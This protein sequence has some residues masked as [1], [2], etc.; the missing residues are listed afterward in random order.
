VPARLP[1]A[2]VAALVSIAALTCAASA[3]AQPDAPVPAPPPPHA[4]TLPQA[5]AYARANQPAVKMALAHIDVEKADAEVPRAAWLPLVGATAQIF[6]GTANNSTAIYSTFMNIPRIGGTRVAAPGSLQPYAS[7]FVGAALTQEVFDFGRIAAQTAAEDARVDV[8]RQHVREAMLDV[9]Y[10]VEE[11][12]FA[13]WAARDIVTA[14][15]QAYERARAHRDLAKAAVDSEMRTPIELARAEADLA[16]FDAGRIRARGGLRLAQAVFA[17]A[18]GVADVAL[19]VASAPPTPGDLPS[20]E[21]SVQ[22]ASARDPR[23]LRVLAEIRA[24]EARTRAIGAQLRPDVSISAAVSGRAGGAP[25]SGNGDTVVAEGFL[26]YVPNWDVGVLLSWPLFDGTVKAREEASRAREAE[27]RQQLDAARYEE[28]ATI[29]AAYTNVEVARATV[30]AL[31]R[32]LEAA[33][34]NYAQA[35]ARFRGGLGTTVELADAEA[36]RTDAQIQLALGEF[37]LARARAAFG[38]AIAEGS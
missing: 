20:L 19:D 4:M 17:A 23:I 9:R 38:R 5:I 32:A 18:V 16:R 14:S 2:I 24:E 3:G 35:D 1:N 26:P 6:G 27:R 12:Y 25:P 15:D 31:R 33:E 28:T 30:P 11:A 8:A 22:R 7:T 29:R 21:D 34:A 10:D 13:V 36:L 37:E